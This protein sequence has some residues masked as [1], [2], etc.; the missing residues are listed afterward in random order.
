MTRQLQTKLE[1]YA[2]LFD[3]PGLRDAYI[4]LSE[5]IV[6]ELNRLR[7]ANVANNLLDAEN[8]SKSH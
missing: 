6:F 4:Y 1:P 3:L 5:K 2:V 7:A 8:S